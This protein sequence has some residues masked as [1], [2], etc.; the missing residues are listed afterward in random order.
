MDLSGSSSRGNQESLESL[1][2]RKA[3]VLDDML[4]EAHQCVA[5]PTLVLPWETPVMSPVFGTASSLP[6]LPKH[7]VSAACG[8]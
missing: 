1:G 5:P 7:S 4:Q 8:V 6:C 2:K 3:S